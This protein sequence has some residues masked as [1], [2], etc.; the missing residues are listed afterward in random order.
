MS[1][2]G[3][4]SGG[5]FGGSGG[6]KEGPVEV[7]PA[8]KMRWGNDVLNVTLESEGLSV[9]VGAASLCDYVSTA[10]LMHHSAAIKAGRRAGGSAQAKLDPDGG[11]GRL[12]AEGKRPSARGFTGK[13]ESLPNILTRSAIRM[14]EKPVR[15]GGRVEQS[16]PRQKGKRRPTSPKMGYAAHATIHPAT[17]L[18]AQWLIDEAGRGNEYFQVVGD[19]DKVITKV[20][21]DYLA[22]AANGEDRTYQKGSFR[23]SDRS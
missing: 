7:L 2:F 9:N 13:A 12:A 14:Q 15:I 19:A 6:D 10:L 5:S 23:A 8:W 17:N 16:G 20:V 18:H 11:Q 22:T 4:S 3:G 1:E 21:A